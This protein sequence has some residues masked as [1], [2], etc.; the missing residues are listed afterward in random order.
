MNWLDIVL[1]LIA[2][3]SIVAG[4]V[5]GITKVGIGFAA[6]VLGIL[7]GLWFYG[8]AGALLAPYIDSRETRNL[9][10]FCLI[11]FGIVLLG[12]LVG[13]LLG[14]LLKLVHLSLLDRLLG[15]AFGFV[16][17]VLLGTVLITV[18]MAFTPKPPPAAVVRSRVAPY[19]MGAARVLASAAPH[20]LK[21]TFQQS[22]DRTHQ[23][24]EGLLKKGA[25]Q[26]EG[27]R[28]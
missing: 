13:W 25:K 22:Y 8:T 9:I 20:D 7:C 24:W 16:R 28:F 15:G 19:V 14:K 3:L 23:I 26:P 27:E 1:L 2:G 6:I 21:K 18:M 11:F 5:K 17:G 10:G 4:F 12:S